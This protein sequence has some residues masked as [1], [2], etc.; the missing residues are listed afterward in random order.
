MIYTKPMV[1][2]ELDEYNELIVAAKEKD[3]NDDVVMLKDVIIAFIKSGVGMSPMA[4]NELSRKGVRFIV[5]VKAYENDVL[6]E[7]INVK[8]DTRP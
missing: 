8:R 7:H 3:S 6:P 1:T 4:G 2:I 5:S